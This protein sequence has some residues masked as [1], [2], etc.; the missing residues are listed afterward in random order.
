MGAAGARAATLTGSF[1]KVTLGATSKVLG[2]GKYSISGTT[3]KTVDVSEFGV[4]IDIFEFGS[5]DGGTISL[6]DVSY[7]P[8]DPEQTT[9]VTNCNNGV[10]FIF[11]TTSGPRFWINSTSY[12]T[13]GTSGTILM[14]SAGKV[15]ADRNGAAKTGF[16]G[17]VSGAFMYLV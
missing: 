10:K 16:E 12:L 5:A 3:R 15:E 11:S 17:K 4:D 13:I 9:F 1:Q 2:A 6:T 7:D 8:T 14:T